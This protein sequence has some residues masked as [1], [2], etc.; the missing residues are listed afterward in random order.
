MITIPDFL[1][2][3]GLSALFIAI[4]AG[5]LGAFVVWQRLAYF[6]DT[7][8]HGAL[9]GV[10]LGLFA[11]INL[12]LAIVICSLAMAGALLLLQHTTASGSDALL[13]LLSHTAL[14]A[15]LVSVSLME[16]PVDI[17][18]YLFGDL[19][20][21]SAEDFW[22]ITGVCIGVMAFLMLAWRP[23]LLCVID[24]DLAKVEGIPV[25]LMKILLLFT[26]AIVVALAIRVVGVL[27]ITALLIIPASAGRLITRTPETMAI[28]SALIGCISVLGGLS[29]SYWYNTP[30]GP[31]VVISSSLL[32]LLVFLLSFAYKKLKTS[33]I[34]HNSKAFVPERKTDHKA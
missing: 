28:L 34:N 21:T 27:L 16:T 12:T 7:L 24:A 17:F 13:G 22:L 14:A 5:P 29:G 23:L 1:L 18:A 20:T 30:A 8:S 31:S 26:I 3:A 11:D 15:G 32:F 33:R 9:L 2:Y 4:V 10:A 19:L 25:H 6:G